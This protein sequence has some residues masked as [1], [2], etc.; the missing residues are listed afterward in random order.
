MV[1]WSGC[2]R[3]G[4]ALIRE[5]DGLHCHECAR[6]WQIRDGVLHAATVEYRYY[7][8]VA[9]ETIAHWR[10]VLAEGREDDPPEIFADDPW[11]RRYVFDR[12]RTDPLYLLGPLEGLR[13]LDVGCGWGLYSEQLARAG[14]E[15]LA[16]DT[17]RERAAWTAA[18]L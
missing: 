17:T 12:G 6:T 7:G 14:A 2:T 10:D 5:R 13:V 15:V 11:M 4:R 1:G 8:E 3:C 9:A 16:L 18:R